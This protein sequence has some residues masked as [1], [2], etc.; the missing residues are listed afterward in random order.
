MLRFKF[1]LPTF[2]LSDSELDFLALHY[3][4]EIIYNP[5]IQCH[6][7]EP[8]FSQ[9]F[10]LTTLTSSL[11]IRNTFEILFKKFQ[12]QVLHEKLMEILMLSLLSSNMPGLNGWPQVTALYR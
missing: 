8:G 4:R 6:P 3:R 12:M 5:T 9:G 1:L 11:L 10:F 2:T 7:D